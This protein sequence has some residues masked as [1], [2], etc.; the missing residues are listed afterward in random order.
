MPEFVKN[1]VHFKSGG[2][3]FNQDRGPDSARGQ[4]ETLFGTKV[5]EDGVATQKGEKIGNGSDSQPV[6]IGARILGENVYI[7]GPAAGE[8]LVDADRT[9]RSGAIL[10]TAQGAEH[11]AVQG[12][13]SPLEYLLDRFFV[14]GDEDRL[15]VHLSPLAVKSSLDR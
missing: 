3:G 11:P 13:Q 4:I 14:V 7:L 5:D 15:D 8:I 1:L 12:G 6:A 2:Q 10:L 9:P